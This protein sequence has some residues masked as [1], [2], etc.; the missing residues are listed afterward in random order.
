MTR[1]AGI[2]AAVAL[3]SVLWSC[4]KEPTD[5]GT[6]RTSMPGDGAARA[7]RLD[8]ALERAATPDIPVDAPLVAVLGDSIA[9]G[10]HLD[11]S[12]AF[13]AVLQ[14]QLALAGQPFRLVNAGVSG[15]TTAGGLRRVD[16]VLA[17]KPQVLI[18]ELGG[19]DGL[20]GQSVSEI[21]DNL[22]GIV[23]K[24]KAAQARVVLCGVRLPTSYGSEYTSAFEQLYSTLASEEGL[25][26]VPYFMEGVGGV[27]EMNLEDGLHPTV[28]GHEH[29][30]R[31]LAP[32]LGRVLADL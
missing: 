13:P 27:P 31:N 3:A 4:S 17:Q 30:A 29:I 20:R 15:D 25:V 12:A 1:S 10:L 5:S 21:L 9:A 6:A 26:L 24:A 22:R 19:N 28:A 11:A 18:V 32:H 2:L 14:R 16:W 7:A 23:R 8:G